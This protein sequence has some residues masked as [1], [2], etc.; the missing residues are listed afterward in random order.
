MRRATTMAHRNPPSLLT[1]PTPATDD[2]SSKLAPHEDASPADVASTVSDAD[3]FHCQ[4]QERFSS[5]F[6]PLGSPVD[7]SEDDDEEDEECLEE[8]LNPI[9]CSAMKP[10]SAAQV[11]VGDRG[12]EELSNSELV[13]KFGEGRIVEAPHRRNTAEVVEEDV[14]QTALVETMD[15]AR[16]FVA[17]SEEAREAAGYE[18]EQTDDPMTGLLRPSI[19]DIAPGSEGRPREERRVQAGYM[20]RLWVGMRSE[21]IVYVSHVVAAHTSGQ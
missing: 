14:P 17:T 13:S 16:G 3:V 10:K 4:L 1:A 12:W 18:T 9:W 8:P 6:L 7:S 19:D 20:S 11:S 5:L 15:I 2:V 21:G